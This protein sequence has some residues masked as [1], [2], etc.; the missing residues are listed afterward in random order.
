MLCK[1]DEIKE[2]LGRQS[3]GLCSVSHGR[4]ILP[5]GALI[6]GL[7]SQPCRCP[8]HRRA[9]MQ[10][11]LATTAPAVLARGRNPIWGDDEPLPL[12]EAATYIGMRV[13][14]LRQ[15]VYAREIAVVMVGK[16]PKVRPSAVRAYLERHER[17]AL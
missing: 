3:D 5:V 4:S 10:L 12:A 16:H 9:D 11:A 1:E 2:L 17:P 8:R 14:T 13:G 15:K 6:A 7:S